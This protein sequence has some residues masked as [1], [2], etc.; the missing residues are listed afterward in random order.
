MKNKIK[1]FSFAFTALILSGCGGGSDDSFP[2]PNPTPTPIPTPARQTAEGQWA[3][4]N[5]AGFDTMLTILEN[6]EIW[7][8]YGDQKNGRVGALF[9]QMNY[10][11]YQISGNINDLNRVSINMVDVNM[12]SSNTR[13]STFSGTFEPKSSL[14]MQLQLTTFSAKYSAAYDAPAQLSSIAGVYNGEGSTATT[15]TQAAKITIRNDG[16]ISMPI[17]NGCSASGEILPRKSGKNVFDLSLK[18]TGKCAVGDGGSVNGIGVYENNSLILEALNADKT[19]G[20]FFVGER[21]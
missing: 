6:G 8:F 4:I 3:G 10:S 14:F 19:V 11:G 20:L 2:S 15:S 21:Q 12:M 9:G 17:V 16:Y 5:S 1:L 18:Y 13:F 7:G